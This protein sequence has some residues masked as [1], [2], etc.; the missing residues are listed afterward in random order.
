MS[1]QVQCE[2]TGE[3]AVYR[4]IWNRANQ[5]LWKITEILLNY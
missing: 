4:Y 5:L 1:L 2:F 3:E